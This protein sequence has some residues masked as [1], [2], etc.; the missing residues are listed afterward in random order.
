MALDP[1]QRDACRLL[2]ARRKASGESYVAGGAALNEI[3]AAARRSRDLDLFHDAREA[4]AE[5]FE[6][7]RRTLT[8]AG[9]S[10]ETLRET[11]GFV[12]AEV[13]RGENRLRIDWS[14]DSAFR[15]FPLVEHD[16]FG[17][18]LHPFDLATNK[19]LALVGRLE[20]R[21]WIDSMTLDERVQPLGYLAWA[22]A[23]K[24]PGFSPVSI[25]EHAARTSH[26]SQA[27][28]DTLDFEGGAPDAGELSRRWRL[29]LS[30][31]REIVHRLPAPEVGKCVLDA[32]SR[33]YR[34]ARA[35]LADDLRAGNLRFHA[36]SLRG[37]FPTVRPS[38]GSS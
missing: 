36:G 28:V 22:A 11:R 4:V 34:G 37:A 1:F 23:G 29:R 8:E 25:L 31:A 12:T 27:E 17:L 13:R 5:S 21:D 7:D 15:F 38:S 24:D 19:V 9:C 32:Q 10:V 2:A 18:T 30:E 26:Y 3:L 14:S 33:L 16:L 6:A 35:Q 20:V